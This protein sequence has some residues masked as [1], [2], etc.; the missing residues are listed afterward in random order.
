MTETPEQLITARVL[1]E[2]TGVRRIALGTGLPQQLIPLLPPEIEVEPLESLDRLTGIDVVVVEPIEVSE[3]GDLVAQG[4]NLSETSPDTR[5]VAAGPM[6]HA[7]GSP[8]LVKQ[9]RLPVTVPRCVNLIINEFGVV[10]VGKVG[11]ELTELAPGRS[12]DDIRLRVRVSLH[13]ADGLS[14]F[15]L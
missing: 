12:S 13:V 6:L 15:R 3:H 5:W 2:L 4:M 8:V 9:C 10:K 11:F 1:R 7:D 14:T